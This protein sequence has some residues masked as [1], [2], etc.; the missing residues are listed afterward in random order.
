MSKAKAMADH[1][2]S[3]GAADPP[4][5]DRDEIAAEQVAALFSNVL[6]GVL[7]AMIGAAVLSVSLYRLGKVDIAT[8]A[9]WT[10]YIAACAFAHIVVRQLYIRANPRVSEWRRWAYI[11]TGVCLAEGIGWG[12]APFGLAAGANFEV[13]LLIFVVVFGVSAGAMAAF[14]PYLPAFFAIFLPA[15]I[16]YA[17]ANVGASSRLS[18]QG[19]C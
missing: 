2:V 9:L 5:S 15:T 7:G 14:G 6:F 18:R 3:F 8:G 19:R 11:L 13:V 1:A 12:W 10:G 4:P 17:V 16:P